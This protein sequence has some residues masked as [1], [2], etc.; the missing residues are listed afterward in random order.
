MKHAGWIFLGLMLVSSGASAQNSITALD[1]ENG[2]GGVIIKVDFAQPLINL[3]SGFTTN[4]PP[5]IV[6]DFIDTING[7]GK[8]ARNFA[9]GNLQSAN[10]IQVA[11][12]TRLV[13]NLDQMLAHNTRIDGNSLLIALQGDATETADKVLVAPDAVVESP[14]ELRFDITGYTLEGAT[15]LSQAE[16]DVAVAPLIGKN[17]DFS[18]VQRALEAVEE[19]YAVR[20]F[21]AVRVL[22]PEQELE[23]GAVRFQVVESRFGKVT[24]KDNRFVGEANV[25][26]ALPSVRGG[27][28]PR[29]KQIARELRFANEN[30]ARQLNVVLKAGEEE[31]LVDANVIV[32]DSKPT[33]WGLTAD[34]TGTAETGRTRLGL[35]WRHANL[36]DADHVGSLQFQT[37]P[38]HTNRVA[39]VGA[40]YKIPLYQLRSSLDFTAG[41]SNVNS[42]LGG[43]DVVKGGGTTLGAHYTHSLDKVGDFEP[44]LTFGLD[45][46]KFSNIYF[47]NVVVSP[48]IVVMPLSASYF[49]QGKLAKSD[50]GFNASLSANLPGMD[51]GRSADFAAYNPLAN[52]H[53]KVARFGASYAQLIGDDW[54]VR[55]ALNGQ[56]SPDTLISGEQMRLGGADAVRGFSEGSAGGDSGM[57]LNLEAYTPNLGSSD[58][59]VRGL[60][61][62]DAGEARFADG[63]KS[64]IASSGVGLRASFAES[65]SLRLD[66]AR[67]INADTDPSQRVGDWRV[68]IGVSASF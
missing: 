1:A 54:Q 31:G 45:W 18:D 32:T 17:K 26:H 38:T 59:M 68:H 6:L 55:A 13:I 62:F 65:F 60:A 11:G 22:L 44:R 57:R 7:L 56:Y 9:Q 28:P 12:R 37:S 34:N 2:N 29:T 40:N 10:I 48:E 30:P 27:N 64:S 43:L 19:A 61:F 21:S 36:F 58:V 3:P 15:L 51:K 46:R 67:I 41:Y 52:P 39:V 53:Y 66:A 33:A 24:V 25:L 5:R 35:S 8:S 49:T 63:T 42:V 23:K 14:A 20:G 50:I 16:V 4:A 47:N